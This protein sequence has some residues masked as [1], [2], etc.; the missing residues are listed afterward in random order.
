MEKKET[1]HFKNSA[2][3]RKIRPAD[4]SGRLHFFSPLLSNAAEESAS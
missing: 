1:K 4:L 2:L 3:L